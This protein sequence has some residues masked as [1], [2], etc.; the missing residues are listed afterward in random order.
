MIN[1]NKGFTLIELVVVISIL[2]IL[3]AFAIPRFVSLEVEARVAATESL[4]GAVRSAAALAHAK[5][6]VTPGAA[7]IDMEGQ[8]INLQNGYPTNTDVALT[9]ADDSGFNFT[10]GPTSVWTKVGANT[11]ANCSV[12]YTPAPAGGSPTI[13][14]DTSDC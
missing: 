13:V 7:S 2:A 3:A 9:L 5:A 14:S 1:G 6:L 10:P 11:P 8:I 12:S 4:E